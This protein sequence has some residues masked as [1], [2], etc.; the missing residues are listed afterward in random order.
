[1]RAFGVAA[2]AVWLGLSGAAAQSLPQLYDVRD[3]AMDD[4]LNIRAEPSADAPILGSLPPDARGIEVVATNEAGTWGQVNTGEGSGW[5]ALRYMSAQGVA[6][7]NYNLPVGLGC[8]G[9]EPFWS[10]D[11]E[12]GALTYSSPD[13]DP[14]DLPLWLAQDTGLPGDLT[15]MLRFAAPS[16]PGVA[17][18]YPAACNDGMSDRAYGLRVALM[19][20]LDGPL[21]TGCCS[22]SR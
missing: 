4:V 11:A 10:L 18:I 14:Q 20:G 21:L 8:F 1:M 9:T 7:D 22:L 5:V 3:V 17:H 13:T 2:L 12:G 19:L 16:G 6:I 15:R